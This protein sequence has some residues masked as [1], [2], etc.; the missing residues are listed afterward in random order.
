MQPLGSPER[1]P[2]RIVCAVDAAGVRPVGSPFSVVPIIY[3]GRELRAGV[4]PAASSPSAPGF[5]TSRGGLAIMRLVRIA[6]VFVLVALAQLACGGSGAVE[7]TSSPVQAT[8]AIPSSSG[9]DVSSYVACEIVTPQEVA[10]LVGGPIFRELEQEPSPACVY[11]IAAGPD[12]YAQ[13]IVSIQPP[14]IADSAIA[15]IPEEL[16][17]PVAGMGDAAYLD[18]DEGADTY[19]LLVLVRGRFGM[20]VTGEGEDWTLAL[21]QLFLSRLLGP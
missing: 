19:S 2:I 18:Y 15:A 7:P 8:E 13:F 12:S 9:S 1:G 21:G 3:L 6:A 16:G 14:D 4:Q 20:N 5:A 17:Q 10:D 11:E